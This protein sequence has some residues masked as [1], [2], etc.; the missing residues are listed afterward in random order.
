MKLDLDK[1]LYMVDV[2]GSGWKSRPCYYIKKKSYNKEY[3]YIVLEERGEYRD[4]Y[5]NSEGR[6]RG[7]WGESVVISNDECPVIVEEE[8]VMTLE[9]FVRKCCEE[10]GFVPD[11]LS[12]RLTAEEMLAPSLAFINIDNSE[13]TFRVSGNNNIKSDIRAFVKEAKRTHYITKLARINE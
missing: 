12:A 3:P 5:I 4:Y 9:D 8:Q 7:R 6:I 1:D 13:H 11:Y 10:E 2:N